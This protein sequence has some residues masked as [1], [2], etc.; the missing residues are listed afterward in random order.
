MD[1][2]LKKEI[3]NYLYTSNGRQRMAL[4]LDWEQC[5]I[6]FKAGKLIN[7]AK[8]FYELGLNERAKE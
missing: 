2:K 8:H 3:E 6:T 4:E 7:F 5:D 1:K